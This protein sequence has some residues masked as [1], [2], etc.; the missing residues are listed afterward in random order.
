MTTAIQSGD[1]IS[2]HYTG[3]LENGEVFDSSEGGD[4][5]KFT[6]GTGQ[7]IKGFDTAVTGMKVG[8]K[9]TANIPPDEGYG[10]HSDEYIIEMPKAGIPEDMEIEKGLQIHLQDQNGQPV[11]G[12]I[13][14]I[15]DE[16]VKVDVN[17]PLSGKTLVFD[18]EIVEV[19]LE[20]DAPHQ[21]ADDHECGCG[22]E[23]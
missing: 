1:T 3:K 6:V 18:I 17:H 15:L 13:H 23:H 22:H 19:G 10:Q 5:L 2:V 4:P 11:P 21:H 12:I 20:A 14:E 16:V 9:V 8:E 7:L